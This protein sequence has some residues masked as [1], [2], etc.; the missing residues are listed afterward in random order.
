MAVTEVSLAELSRG[1]VC[2][3]LLAGSLFQ[4]ASFFANQ[5]AIPFLAQAYV[6]VYNLP[7]LSN[8]LVL[9][10]TS[11]AEIF[12]GKTTTWNDPTLIS[13]NPE[14]RKGKVTF[15]ADERFCTPALNF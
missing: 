1:V 15:N 6:I 9:D 11:I 4:T 10:S 8:P 13:L 5:K 14:L 2:I 7:E 3:H 12:L